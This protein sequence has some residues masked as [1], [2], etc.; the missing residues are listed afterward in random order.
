MLT[1]VSPQFFA[2]LKQPKEYELSACNKNRVGEKTKKINKQI[3]EESLRQSGPAS[4]DA[5]V[6]YKNLP[7]GSPKAPLRILVRVRRVCALL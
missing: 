1:E 5:I 6:S 7:A 2:F 3:L 4:W